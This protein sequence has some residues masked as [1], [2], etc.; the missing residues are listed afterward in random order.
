MP[1]SYTRLMCYTAGVGLGVVVALLLTFHLIFKIPASPQLLTINHGQV[2]TEKEVRCFDNPQPLAIDNQGRLDLLVWNIYKQ[3]RATWAQELTQFSQHTQLA[4]L[5]EASMTDEL[6]Q[7]VS[8]GLWNSNQVKAFDALDTT[9]GVLN[10]ASELPMTACAYTAMEPWLKLPKSALFA[11][12][13]LSSNEILAVVNIH[14][15]NFTLGTQEYHTQLLHLSDALK[16]H[17]GPIIVAGDFNSWSS[18]RVAV[19][20]QSLASL[21]LL[22]VAFNPDNRIQPFDGIPLDHIFYRGLILES[23][24][25]PMTDASDHT[26]LVARFSLGNDNVDRP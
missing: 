5:Q 15:V 11:R 25:A 8:D 23:A 19:M 13:A 6:K 21:G 9:S 16:D 10:L 18:E 22:E 17:Q 14:A 3:N 24:E 1:K 2:E 12:Y 7:W 20:K 26:P 4:L